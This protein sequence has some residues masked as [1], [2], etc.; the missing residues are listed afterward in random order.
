MKS[1]SLDWLLRGKKLPVTYYVHVELDRK[2]MKGL[3]TVKQQLT[4]IHQLIQLINDVKKGDGISAVGTSPILK[5][6]I[7]GEGGIGKSCSF[8]RLAFDWAK[9]QHPAM[10]EFKFVFLILLR[11]VKTNEPLENIIIAQ[12][13]NFKNEGISPE[14]LK[15]VLKEQNIL[16]ML[17][18]L[19]EYRMKTNEAIDNL[20]QYNQDNLLILIS[21]RPDE[22]LRPIKETSHEVVRMTGFNETSI[23]QAGEHLLGAAAFKEFQCQAE[24]TVLF[25]LFYIPIILLMACA[26]FEDNQEL[27][28]TQTALFEQILFM[29]ISRTMLKTQGKPVK[30]LKDLDKMLSPGL[31]VSLGKL[32]WNA[33]KGK[34]DQLILFKVGFQI[35]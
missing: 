3:K 12:H 13:R 33:L 31:L 4:S 5:V 8:A 20:I 28:S 17:D 25:R 24:E 19:D 30:D 23:K 10:R 6:V 27:P 9:D 7:Q 16:I 2:I 21:S 11:H 14:Q 15:S 1:L 32:A 18:G 34:T 26:I 35:F 29:L 22:F